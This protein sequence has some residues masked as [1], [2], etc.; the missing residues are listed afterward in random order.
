MRVSVILMLGGFILLIL[1]GIPAVFQFLK[2]QGME[3]QFAYF[4]FSSHWFIMIYGFFLMLIGNEILVALSY[5]WSRKK[6][7]DWYC[8]LF[9]SLVIIASFNY[10][11]SSLKSI[12]FILI[13]IAVLLLLFHS[14]IFLQR[15]W[16]NLKPLKYIR[17][18]E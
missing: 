10:A 4:L 7:K 15:S 2:K 12:S 3:V 1:S 6:A 13:F 9:A 18:L 11:F 5:E 8:I 14:R 17:N 16:I